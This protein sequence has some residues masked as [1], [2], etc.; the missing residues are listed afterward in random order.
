V[1]ET[2]L[3]LFVPSQPEDDAEML[4]ER[5][6]SYAFHEL[7]TPLTVVH[8]YAQIALDK[9]PAGPENETLR[10]ILNRMISQG[11]EMVEMIEELLEASRIPLGHLNLDQNEIELGELIECSI[12]CLPDDLRPYVTFPSSTRPYPVLADPPR[13]QH[14]FDILIKFALYEQQARELSPNLQ[15]V[16]LSNVPTTTIKLHLNAP[17]L[18][19]EARQDLFD[20]YRPVRGEPKFL[21]K[22]GFLDIG[23]YLARGIIE[24]HGGRLDYT[25]E[26]SGFSLELPLIT[27]S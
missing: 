23:L 4:P 21:T 14:A 7:R 13:L 5:F 3:N 9:L 1:A 19:L 26:L 24:A 10:R 2:N 8:S 27:S 15:I 18:L 22:A 25:P 11:E 12:E 20:L 16:Y 6:L 17:G